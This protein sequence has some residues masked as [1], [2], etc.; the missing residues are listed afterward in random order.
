[1]EHGENDN[2][3]RIVFSPT[4]LAALIIALLGGSGVATY[5]LKPPESQ[6]MIVSD[7]HSRE[8][9]DSLTRLVQQVAGIEHRLDKLE[10]RSDDTNGL[11]RRLL[12]GDRSAARK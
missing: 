5:V 4:T 9:H 11:V 10:E 3:Q 6:A 8:D 7:V 1:M 2:G 12:Y